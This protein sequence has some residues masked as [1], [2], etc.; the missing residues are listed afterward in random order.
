MKIKYGTLFNKYKQMFLFKARYFQIIS[1]KLNTENLNAGF[2]GGL[3]INP[4]LKQ[5]ENSCKK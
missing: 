4:L 1:E 5:E 2:I 3:N